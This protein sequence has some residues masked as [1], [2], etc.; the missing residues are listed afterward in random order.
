MLGW[1]GNTDPPTQDR[2]AG[3]TVLALVEMLGRPNTHPG[4]LQWP[5]AASPIAFAMLEGG[6]GARPEG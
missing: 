6:P 3:A 4:V 1:T 5:V 2:N